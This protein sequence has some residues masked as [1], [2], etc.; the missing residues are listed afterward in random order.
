MLIQAEEI[1]K[2]IRDIKSLSTLPHIMTR[3][4]AVAANEKSSA[5]DLSKEVRSD[6]ALASKIL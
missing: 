6:Q 1:Q 2:K 5:K 4:M 3:I